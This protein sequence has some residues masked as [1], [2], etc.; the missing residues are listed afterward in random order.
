MIPFNASLHICIW[1][2]HNE[3]VR[4]SFRV[5]LYVRSLRPSTLMNQIRGI[6]FLWSWDLAVLFLSHNIPLHLVISTT[7]FIDPRLRGWFLPSSSYF[8]TN[9]LKCGFF[10]FFF[11]FDSADS[12]ANAKQRCLS[13]EFYRFQEWKYSCCVVLGIC[14]YARYKWQRTPQRCALCGFANEHTKIR[15]W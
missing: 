3:V 8:F 12:F 5:C 2:T 7:G 14:K 11:F 1:K 13:Q 6:D 15:I 9:V 10:V 4:P